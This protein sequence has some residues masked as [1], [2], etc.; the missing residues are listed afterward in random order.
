MSI[1]KIS[2]VLRDRVCFGTIQCLVVAKD[3]NEKKQ[4]KNNFLALVKDSSDEITI[5]FPWSYHL[6][7]NVG[8]VYQISCFTKK[9]SKGIIL[10][11][12]ILFPA[13]N[14]KYVDIDVTKIVLEYLKYPKETHT[15]N[16]V[17][18]V[19][20]IEQSLKTNDT[21]N[22]KAILLKAS[23]VKQKFFFLDI[24]VGDRVYKVRI[25]HI[26]DLSHIKNVK[27]ITLKRVVF[28]KSE[29]Y[30]NIPLFCSTIFTQV[31]ETE[32]KCSAQRDSLTNENNVSK[33]TIGDIMK[34]G[35]IT[36]RYIKV[37]KVLYMRFV[38]F[39]AKCSK[40]DEIIN[41]GDS[42]AVSGDIYRQTPEYC[43][44][45]NFPLD[46][47]QFSVTLDLTV[48]ELS[49]T[50]IDK[51]FTILLYDDTATQ[52]LKNTGNNIQKY[53]DMYS[54]ELIV[55]HFNNR[56]I[57]NDYEFELQIPYTKQGYEAI[58]KRFTCT[59]LKLINFNTKLEDEAS[60]HTEVDIKDDIIGG[61]YDKDN[62]LTINRDT[63]IETSSTNTIQSNNNSIVN[64]NYDLPEDLYSIV[65]G[66]SVSSTLHKLE[67]NTDIQK[68]SLA[69]QSSSPP[70]ISDNHINDDVDLLDIPNKRRRIHD[71][72]ST[73]TSDDS[74]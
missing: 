7:I 47:T 43:G 69:L 8:H 71:D 39:A 58:Y 23:I 64:H 41:K 25:Q 54:A 2:S 10:T 30:N 70:N 14:F 61:L 24:Q 15:I 4:K 37:C 34:S 51:P 17:T 3:L 26:K 56:I 45:C 59:K 38:R 42:A 18:D 60:P 29:A 1:I 65:S 67:P 57:N 50:C 35:S 21:V 6:Q 63:D 44:Q 22:L 12:D 33:E 52:L 40:C 28:I 13:S 31:F 55:E 16:F 48:S 49:D 66:P 32:N 9:A 11:P 46:N 53:I 62:E 68:K 73:S 72:T 20:T 27:F 5:L 36:K 74:D 19:Q